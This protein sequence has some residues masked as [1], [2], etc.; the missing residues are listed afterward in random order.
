MVMEMTIEMM[1]NEAKKAIE[2]FNKYNRRCKCTYQLEYERIIV[3]L[4]DN[5]TDFHVQVYIRLTTSDT[6]ETIKKILYDLKKD[7]VGGK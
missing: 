4:Y 6:Y 2:D 3:T 7:T 1:H 5:K